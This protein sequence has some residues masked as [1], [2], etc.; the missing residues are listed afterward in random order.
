ML[1]PDYL[2]ALSRGVEH[3][4]LDS[5]CEHVQRSCRCGATSVAVE[6]GGV[7]NF[8]D[9]ALGQRWVLGNH[10]TYPGVLRQ[11]FQDCLRLQR[12]CV[13]GRK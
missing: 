2:P 8:L 5:S 3:I 11:R 1:A 12:Y 7:Q 9:I 10:S 4:P 6:D 13:G